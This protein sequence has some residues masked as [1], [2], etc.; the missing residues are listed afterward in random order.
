MCR[1]FRSLAVGGPLCVPACH[2]DV[3]W[4]SD[5]GRA[6]EG[7]GSDWLDE[8]RDLCSRDG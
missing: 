2:D 3:L 6:G 4:C 8:S 5:A 7:F 1:R